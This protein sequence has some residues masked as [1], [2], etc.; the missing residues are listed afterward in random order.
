MPS[1]INAPRPKR[2]AVALP[3]I[4]SKMSI[5][6]AVGKGGDCVAGG[7]YGGGVVGGCAVAVDDG[8]VGGRVFVG[9]GDVGDVDVGNGVPVTV[10]IGVSVAVGDKGV[11]VGDGVLVRAGV[12]VGGGEGV[13]VAIGGMVGVDVGKGVLVGSGVDVGIGVAVAGQ[14]VTGTSVRGR[15]VG[16]GSCPTPF[17][18]KAG[19]AF[20]PMM[21]VA[22]KLASN[23]MRLSATRRTI[24]RLHNKKND[25]TYWTPYTNCV[26]LTRCNSL[27][28]ATVFCRPRSSLLHIHKNV[29]VGLRC[30]KPQLIP[31]GYPAQFMGNR[32]PHLLTC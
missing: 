32:I 9:T 23:R 17:S 5:G 6:V 31:A 4:G 21:S 24:K 30:E 20:S 2:V 8:V 26:T 14:G 13:C 27:I 25:D 15:G 22:T 16:R 18:A 29:F 7:E 11:A 19:I 1:K 3:V 12:D 10:G 28:A